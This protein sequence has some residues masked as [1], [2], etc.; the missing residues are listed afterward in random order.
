MQRFRHQDGAAAV[1]FGLLLPLLVMLVFGIIEFSTAYNRSQGMQAAVRE[2]ARL[3]ASSTSSDPVTLEQVRIRTRN[4]LQSNEG[5]SGFPA[6]G[7]TQPND[8]AQLDHDVDIAVANLTG[9]ADTTSPAL[10]SSGDVVCASG[11]HSVRIT[12]SIVGDRQ[13]DYGLVLPLIPGSPFELDLSAE[14]IFRCLG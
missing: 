10:M 11:V 12:A 3:A 6:P 5:G 9:P 13:S 1:E 7:G 14:A 2:G 8:D 4:T